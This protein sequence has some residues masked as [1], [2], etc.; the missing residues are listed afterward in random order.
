MG[1]LA[2]WHREWI[3]EQRWILGFRKFVDEFKAKDQ[4]QNCTINHFIQKDRRM[5]FVMTL[6]VSNALIKE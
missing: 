5:N 3:L 4:L 2:V 6:F 1:R